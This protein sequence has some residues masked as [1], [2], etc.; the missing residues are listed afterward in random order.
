[1]S[2]SP[3]FILSPSHFLM[4]YFTFLRT[5]K[6]LLFRILSSRELIGESA[7]DGL[8]TLSVRIGSVVLGDFVPNR[9]F[10]VAKHP[11]KA[12]HKAIPK[13]LKHVTDQRVKQV[14]HSRSG[15]SLFTPKLL[16]PIGVR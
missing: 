10:A 2:F 5:E 16:N 8:D 14:F 9:N 11:G 13:L 12:R 7:E 15:C 1:M 6:I 3:V 4:G